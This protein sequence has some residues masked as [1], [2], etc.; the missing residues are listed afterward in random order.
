MGAAKYYKLA[1]DQGYSLGQYSYGVCLENGQGVSIDLMGAAKYHKLAADQDCLPAQ[2]A[3]GLCCES[4]RGVEIDLMNAAKYYKLTADQGHFLGQNKYGLCLEN[5]RGVPIDLIRSAQY[6]KLAADYQHAAGQYNYG[7]CLAKGRGVAMDLTGA[8]NYY[9]LASAQNNAD[10]Q[11]LYGQCAE[12]GIGLAPNTA[13]AAEFYQRSACVQHAEGLNRLGTGLE[14]GIGLPKDL[15]RACD[16]YKSAAAKGNANA[17]FNYGFCLQHGLGCPPSLTESLKYYEMSLA[18][19]AGP[20]ESGAFEYGRCLQYGIGF[21]AN[22]EEASDF[23]ELAVRT[24]QSKTLCHSFRCLRGLNRATLRPFRSPRSTE[25][26]GQNQDYSN[27]IRTRTSSQLVSDYVTKPIGLRPGRDI[28]RGGTSRVRSVRDPRT[29]TTIAVKYLPCATLDKMRFVREVECLANLNHPCVLRILHWAFPTN[30]QWAE[31]HTEYAE[32]GSLERCIQERKIKIETGMWT[33]TKIGI[34]ICDIVLGMRFVHSRQIIH[35]D[36]KP[37]NVLIRSNGRALVGDFGSSRFNRDDGT[38]T[39]AGE[40]ATVHY[41]APELFVEGAEV[42]PK[43]DVWGFG[44]ILFEIVAGVPVFPILEVPFDVIRQMRHRKRPAI[45]SECGEYMAGL[46]RRCWSDDRSCRPSFAAILREFQACR[47]AILPG[48]G[49]DELQGVV[50][51]VLKWEF[52]AGMSQ[53]QN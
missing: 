9:R 46:I 31:I 18:G 4:G 33:A 17:Q 42:T 15:R 6:F 51:G 25:S 22:L 41:A 43:I 27:T 8:V 39:S 53:A 2:F 10:A 20:D 40:S 24:D 35:R 1:A 5:S 36:L 29:G 16:C 3:Y 30:S 23:F 52:D 50:D 11:V 21:D 47:F 28:G 13:A 26:K 32:Q 19:L 14:F 38:L 49:C 34:L 44:L 37:S 12:L 7:R 48:V 45:P